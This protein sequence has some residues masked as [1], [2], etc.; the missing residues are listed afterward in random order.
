MEKEGE[1]KTLSRDAAS[2]AARRRS[3]VDVWSVPISPRRLAVDW[4]AVV[5]AKSISPILTVDQPPCAQQ[6]FQ[7]YT[8]SPILNQL[9]ISLAVH[10][11]RCFQTVLSNSHHQPQRYCLQLIIPATSTLHRPLAIPFLKTANPNSLTLIA[12]QLFSS[13]LRFISSIT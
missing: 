7:R 11:Y 2:R 1:E 4:F 13:T 12:D 9:Q 5:T 8:R 3:D 10:I 6:V